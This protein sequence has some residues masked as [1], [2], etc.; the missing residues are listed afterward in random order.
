MGNR[1]NVVH[2]TDLHLFADR[3]DTLYGMNTEKSFCAVLE[4]IQKE[5]VDPIDFMVITGDLVHDESDEGYA[6]LKQYLS[7]LG[8]PV[9]LVS[10]NHDDPALMTKYFADGA[11]GA[12]RSLRRNN[13]RFIFLDTY[14]AG[15]IGGRL[16]SSTL[17]EVD[18]LLKQNPE[19]PTAIFM[20]HPPVGVGSDWLDRIALYNA[21]E[22]HER[23]LMW[24]NLKLVVCG[25][26]HQE[27]ELEQ[28]GVRYLTTPSTCMQ[29]EPMQESFSL[30]D[31]LPGW[32]TLKFFDDGTFCSD[33]R[34]LTKT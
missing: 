19:E 21:L 34:R 10:G 28:G 14:E 22:F 31:R 20:H 8:I 3:D 26:V 6:K 30:D 5:I 4:N 13:W 12:E 29:F 18:Q 17:D 1:L 16:Q 23:T 33:V 7:Q 15:S 2:L 27:R 11:Y 9:Y 24:P 25:H 32:R